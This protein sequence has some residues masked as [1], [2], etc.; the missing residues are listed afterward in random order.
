MG[1]SARTEKFNTC[2]NRCLDRELGGQPS[3]HNV[4]NKINILYDEIIININNEPSVRGAQQAFRHGNLRASRY[5]GTFVYE[6]LFGNNCENLLLLLER[7]F[8]QGERAF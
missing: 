3:H 2:E 1:A 8:I 5:S 4:H 6:P 7:P